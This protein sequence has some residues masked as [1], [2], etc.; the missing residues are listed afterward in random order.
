MVMVVFPLKEK[1]TSSLKNVVTV[2]SYVIKR[3][4]F[5]ISSC[6]IIGNAQRIASSYK[7][8]RLSEGSNPT[9]SVRLGVGIVNADWQRIG[10]LQYLY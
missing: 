3:M 5:Y 6:S 10:V 8:L 2:E 7:S 4:A 9:R 1:V